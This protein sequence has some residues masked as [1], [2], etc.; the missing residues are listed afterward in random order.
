MMKNLG[1]IDGGPLTT[2][3]LGADGAQALAAKAQG[4]TRGAS[5]LTIMRLRPE[6]SL[7]PAT[8]GT[9]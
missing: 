5:Q 4:L 7:V 3:I 1:E 6:L 9:D 2:K 8:T